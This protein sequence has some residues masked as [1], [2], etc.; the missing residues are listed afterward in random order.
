[1]LWGQKYSMENIHQMVKNKFHDLNAL[2]IKSN[3]C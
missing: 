2:N 3:M 1:M